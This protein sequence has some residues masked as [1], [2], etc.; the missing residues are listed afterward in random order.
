VV[1]HAHDGTLAVLAL[2]LPEREVESL[3]AIHDL[4][5]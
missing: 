1:V 4:P 3:L 2:D 5:P